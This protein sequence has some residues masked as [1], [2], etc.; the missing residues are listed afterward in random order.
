MLAAVGD[1]GGATGSA[2]DGESPVVS[3]DSVTADGCRI[4]STVSYSDDL[5]PFFDESPFY[6]EYGVDVSDLPESILTIPVLAQVCPVAW[7][8]GAD[9]R[10]PVADRRFLDSLET[11]GNALC[12][13]YP[14]MQGGRVT[15]ER[16]PE[17][18]DVV[19]GRSETAPD[20]DEAAPTGT[21][22]VSGTEPADGAGMLFTGGVDSLATYVRHR[23][24]DP[25]LITIQGWV[26][27][28]DEPERWRRMRARTESFADR[29]GVDARFVR[30]NMLEFLDTAM[31]DARYQTHHDGA[32]YSAVGCG[33]GLLGLCAPLAVADGMG[34]LYV[35]ASVWEGM[36][37]PPVVDGWDGR[38]M[39]WGTHPDIDDEVAWADS[40][41]V[42]DLFELER[43]ERIEVVADYARTHDPDLPV[44]SCSASEAA[45]N[46]GRCE[47]CIRTA[48]GLALVGLDP[49]DHGF[50]VGRESFEHAVERFEA[51]AWLNDQHAPYHW[52]TFQ[53]RLP[54]DADLPMAGSDA[55]VR[56]LRGADFESMAGRP[57][58]DRLV[59]TVA[60][61]TPYPVY[62]RVSPL[63][64]S[65]RERLR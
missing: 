7:A 51:G 38:A 52:Q 17:W 32:W 16:A 39:P 14:F 6:A 15:A 9:V 2:P 64:G 57:A 47:K 65:V 58:R 50:D 56:W 30:S 53:E 3:V 42:H 22:A 36:E 21:G 23:G 26:V 13:M 4:E 60:R 27:G 62:E 59:R 20:E 49:S 34:E 19:S 44:Y 41:G 63:Y 35:A 33:L 55:F 18:D 61:H 40:T 48:L 1:A 29:F 43:Q 12:A 46:C 54:A 37:P 25:T 45:E 10:V 8:A 5:R 31:L 11:V 28:V 24:E